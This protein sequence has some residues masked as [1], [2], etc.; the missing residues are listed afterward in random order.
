MAPGSRITTALAWPIVL[1]MPLIHSWYVASSAAVAGRHSLPGR[2]L[3]RNTGTPP[4]CPAAVTVA[5][6]SGLTSGPLRRMAWGTAASLLMSSAS[7]GRSFFHCS[8]W[9][10]AAGSG[11]E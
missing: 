6:T 10:L 4:A 11:G 8:A 7:F 5:S 9:R 3:I 1:A 2:E